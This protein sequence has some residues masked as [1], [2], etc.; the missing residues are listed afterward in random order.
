VG[1]PAELQAA[2]FIHNNGRVHMDRS[3]FASS[4]STL[5]LLALFSSAAIADH[6]HAQA[7]FGR[8][9]NTAGLPPNPVNHV[10]FPKL[11]IV[12]AGGVVDFSVAGF[13]DI[14]AFKPGFSLQDLKNAGGGQYPGFGP[15]LGPPG[16][17]YVLPPVPPTATDPWMGAVPFD[18]VYY[19]GIRPAGGPEATPVTPNPS[20]VDNRGEPVTFLERGAYLVICNIRPHLN[21]GMY[22]L[23]LAF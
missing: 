8:G 6:N 9:L 1:C 4:L 10:I 11:I 7:A 17:L 2:S 3:T 23:V 16:K 14:I 19:L 22:A 18:K 15:D 20:N 13:H 5:A 12:K 21:D